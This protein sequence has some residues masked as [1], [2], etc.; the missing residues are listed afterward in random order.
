MI[1]FSSEDSVC[2]TNLE[3]MIADAII[4]VYDGCKPHNNWV[5]ATKKKV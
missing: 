3:L 5:R 2:Y 1:S 4:A